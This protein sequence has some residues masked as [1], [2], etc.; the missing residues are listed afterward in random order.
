[1]REQLKNMNNKD[2]D[3]L[4]IVLSKI[5][6]HDCDNHVKYAAIYI[7]EE[8]KERFKGELSQKLVDEQLQKI[9]NTRFTMLD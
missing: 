8:Y 1:M 9:E 7:L 3:S 2:L 6:L 5:N 4:R